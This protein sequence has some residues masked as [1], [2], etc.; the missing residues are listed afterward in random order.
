MDVGGYCRLKVSGGLGTVRNQDS[1]PNAVG[2]VRRSLVT[3]GRTPEVSRNSFSHARA[4]PAKS[5][6]PS[7]QGVSAPHLQ[8]VEGHWGLA[9]ENKMPQHFLGH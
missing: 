8:S 6:S 2:G 9:T 3:F 4:P 7:D 5:I 1:F